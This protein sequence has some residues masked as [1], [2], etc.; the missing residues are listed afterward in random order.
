[1]I[2]IGVIFSQP[3]TVMADQRVAVAQDQVNGPETGIGTVPV[4]ILAVTP[5]GNRLLCAAMLLRFEVRLADE[6]GHVTVL[7]KHMGDGTFAIP[8]RSVVQ[9]YAVV[10]GFLAGYNSVARR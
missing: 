10:A 8:H 6:M 3:L 7:V 5:I 4:G 9:G 2:F 1:M